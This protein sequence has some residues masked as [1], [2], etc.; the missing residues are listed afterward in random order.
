MN[1]RGEFPEFRSVGNVERLRGQHVR[2]VHALGSFQGVGG[3][4]RVRLGE[5][6]R[7]RGVVL[8]L[9]LLHVEVHPVRSLAVRDSCV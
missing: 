7:F 4:E 3:H 6:A 8:E 2:R 1:G 9:V 5:L